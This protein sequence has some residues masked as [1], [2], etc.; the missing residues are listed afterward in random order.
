MQSRG[1]S[2]AR[3]CR[4]L[5]GALLLVLSFSARALAQDECL[6][7]VKTHSSSVPD[8]GGSLCAV[9]SGKVC[10]FDLELCR[11]QPG[12]LPATF[13]KTI[14]ASGLCNPGKLRMTKAQSPSGAL[15][16]GKVRTK[17]N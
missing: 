2:D 5:G 9:A 7:E 3:A 6:V 15:T 11:N 16:G 13:K 14:R 4:L 17:K 1:S 12:C 10:S 8:T